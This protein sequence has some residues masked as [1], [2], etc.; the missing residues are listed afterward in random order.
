MAKEFQEG[1]RFD[2]YLWTSEHGPENTS[3]VEMVAKSSYQCSFRLH[4]MFLARR[5]VYNPRK[6]VSDS[7]I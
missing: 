7:D 5:V 2:P 3:T 4:I 1:K 6:A